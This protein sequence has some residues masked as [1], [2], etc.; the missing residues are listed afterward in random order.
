MA[1]SPITL[2]VCNCGNMWFPALEPTRRRCAI[3]HFDSFSDVEYESVRVREVVGG[4]RDT[5]A[6][7]ALEELLAYLRCGKSLPGGYTEVTFSETTPEVVEAARV[8]FSDESGSASPAPTAEQIEAGARA[9]YAEMRKAAPWDALAE[10]MR[11]EV[12]SRVRAVLRAALS[13]ERRDG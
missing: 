13:G 5:E 9:L 1:P 3:G 4:D 7:A 6:R 8:V 11:E 10:E 12:R 2:R